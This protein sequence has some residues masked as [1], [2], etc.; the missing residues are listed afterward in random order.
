MVVVIGRCSEPILNGVDHV[1]LPEGL[2]ETTVMS[3]VD[4][5]PVAGFSPVGSKI[6]LL[7]GRVDC[8]LSPSAGMA[9]VLVWTC[10]DD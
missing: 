4:L 5:P 8:L 3:G 2:A 9:M 7:N 1:A 6:T 10:P